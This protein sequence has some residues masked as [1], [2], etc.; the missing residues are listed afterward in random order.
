MPHW[1]VKVLLPQR[2]VRIFKFKG[3]PRIRSYF[4][5]NHGFEE[6]PGNKKRVPSQA[7]YIS[8]ADCDGMIQSGI[9]KR[10]N[11]GYEHLDELLDKLKSE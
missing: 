7:L 9:E 6:L 3:L 2:I 8:V 10:T 11:E 4:F 1:N 5:G